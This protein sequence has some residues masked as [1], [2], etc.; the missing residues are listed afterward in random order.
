M[1]TAN[2]TV[3]ATTT[4][5]AAP[6][7][8]EVSAAIASLLNAQA[9]EYQSISARAAAFHGAFVN[10]LNA[11]A[12]SYMSTEFANTHAAAASE[13]TQFY[14]D[15]P[16]GMLLKAEMEFIELPLDAIG[17]VVTSTAALGQSGST[18][19]NAVLAGN[20]DAATAALR[21]VGPNVGSAFLYGQNTMSIPL[22][23][24]IAGVS[25]A[26]NIPFGGLL[27]PIQP[28][29]ATVT[30]GGPFAGQPPVTVP[31]PFEVGGIVTEV[32]TD[33]E[34]VALALLLSPLVFPIDPRNNRNNWS[35]FT[36]ASCSSSPLGDAV[37]RCDD[38]RHTS[39]APHGS[40]ERRPFRCSCRGWL[41][42]L[43]RRS[44]RREALPDEPLPLRG[45]NRHH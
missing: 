30:F 5:I 39:R 8:D 29:T 24:N 15:G 34:S 10:L 45:G 18:F 36:V 13:F 11:A 2:S 22:P 7:A 28:M 44:A 4:G 6:A 12:G 26:L 16:L 19:V 21:D 35:R 31:M 25:V 3:V 41:S 42:P 40:A 1:S 27:A 17:P 14:G 33:P 20:S 43:H 37:R 23:S 38:H 32:Q 9:L